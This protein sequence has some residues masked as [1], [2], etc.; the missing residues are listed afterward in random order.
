[1][2]T[3][4]EIHR[5]CGGRVYWHLQW[6]EDWLCWTWLPIC[7]IHGGP[8]DDSAITFRGG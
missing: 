1:M 6:W 7:R 4:F 2:Q 5:E 8:L 3:K